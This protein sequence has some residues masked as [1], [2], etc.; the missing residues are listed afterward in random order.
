MSFIF[1][2]V[3]KNK[4]DSL[5]TGEFDVKIIDGGANDI[6][7]IGAVALAVMIFICAVGMEWETKAQ[8]FLLAIIVAAIFNF[9]IGSIYGPTVDEKV[10]RGF[11][12]FNGKITKQKPLFCQGKKFFLF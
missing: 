4:I 6:R 3:S 8:N 11:V 9:L 5:F 7:I 10:Q 2:N 12:G 1:Q